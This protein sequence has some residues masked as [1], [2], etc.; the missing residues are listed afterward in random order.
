MG[1][2]A[3]TPMPGLF[4]SLHLLNALPLPVTPPGDQTHNT[5]PF[6]WHLRSNSSRRRMFLQHNSQDPDTK[7]SSGWKSCFHYS[8]PC[9]LNQ[10]SESSSAIVAVSPDVGV[11]TPT[12]VTAALVEE[13]GLQRRDQIKGSTLGCALTKHD[14][15]EMWRHAERKGC[16]WGTLE[17][18]PW[19]DCSDCHK[20]RKSEEIWHLDLGL[21]A[22]GTI[23]M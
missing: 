16:E 18:S 13:I 14:C 2:Q 12:H 19:E 9:E 3:C 22:S 17:E 15:I 11:L 10:P 5:W 6:G 4:I 20:P 21:L 1:L 8:Q 7:V 23:R